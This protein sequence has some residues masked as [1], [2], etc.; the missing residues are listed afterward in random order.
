MP[1]TDDLLPIS[2]LAHLAYC[3][4]RFGLVVLDAQFIENSAVAEGLANHAVLARRRRRGSGDCREVSVV[5]ERLGLTGRVDEVVVEHGGLGIIERKRSG[6]SIE[7]ENVQVCA[8]AVCLEET[9]GQRVVSAAVW[10]VRRRVKRE[11]PVDAEARARLV[12]AVA[13]AR[14]IIDDGRIP[15]VPS[16]RRRC[17]G[18]SME[19]LCQT[20]RTNIMPSVD[21]PE[22]FP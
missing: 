17:R 12:V 10:S 7:T 21:L 11:V 18:C 4:R 9:T 2:A 8:E 6:R 1:A 15:P 19:P 14:A 16:D 3:E 13:R 22:D 20:G 5:S